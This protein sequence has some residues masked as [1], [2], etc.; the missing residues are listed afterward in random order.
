MTANA[1]YFYR[2]ATRLFSRDADIQTEPHGLTAVRL[3]RV[4]AKEN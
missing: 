2:L 1:E 3:F 4:Y